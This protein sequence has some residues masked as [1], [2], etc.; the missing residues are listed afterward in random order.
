MLA[1]ATATTAAG[2]ATPSIALYQATA[3]GFLVLLLTGVLAEVRAFR[4][5]PRAAPLLGSHRFTLSLFGG[6]I[7]LAGAGEAMSLKMLIAPVGGT[8][9]RAAV[10]AC[11]GLTF[12]SVA[13]LPFA[14]MWDRAA[15]ARASLRAGLELARTAFALG[16]GVVAI[17]VLLAPPAPRTYRVYGTCAAGACGLNERSAPRAS[18]REL[19]KLADGTRVVITCQTSGPPPP[20]AHSRVWDRI[21]VAHAHGPVYVSD[22]YVDTPGN[23]VTS[24]GLAG[25]ANTHGRSTG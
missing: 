8:A 1:S 22:A 20:T 5:G 18:A 23:G 12:L 6:A 4:D 10:L 13:V 19:G 11:F 16:L 24:P 2:G 21:A 25:C 17:L 15:V 9:V 7:L 3:P 14:A